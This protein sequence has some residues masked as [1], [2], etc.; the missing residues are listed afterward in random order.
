MAKVSTS[1]EEAY[2]LSIL[3]QGRDGITINK[4]RLIT[5]A[6]NAAIQMAS[7]GYKPPVKEKNIKV[8]GIQGLG[9]FES[10]MQNMKAGNFISEHDLKISKKL[11]YVMCGGDLSHPT[12]VSEQ[13]LLDLE[14]EAFVSLCGEK[15]TMERI[16]HTL[17][18]G[19]P[20]RN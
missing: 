11:A 13:Y 6:K 16:Q 15:K 12:Y 7:K 9:M 19:K 10:G 5:D 8:L 3:K 4:D 17:K 20:L 18:T 14:R 2:D 1:A